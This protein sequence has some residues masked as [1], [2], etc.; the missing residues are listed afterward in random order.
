MIT[1]EESGLTGDQYAALQGIVHD[2]TY[3]IVASR[4]N[5]A[6][7]EIGA[8]TATASA[9]TDQTDACVV[10]GHGLRVRTNGNTLYVDRWPNIGQASATAGWD[11]EGAALVWSGVDSSVPPGL[12]SSG[13]TV[14]VFFYDGTS[15]KYVESTDA[16]ESWGSP[17]TAVAQANV[18][19]LAPTKLTKVHFAEYR[20]DF[21]TRLHYAED[22]SGWDTVGSE[23][24]WSYLMTGFDAAALDADTDVIV[25]SSPFPVN[26][27]T[28]AV[29]ATVQ[30]VVYQTGGVA[31][32]IQ[33]NE[34]W[35]D[36]C[37]IDVF[38]DESVYRYR[39]YPRIAYLND[40]LMVICAGKDGDEQASHF[41]HH[42]YT[43]KDG[44][45]WRFEDLVL[46]GDSTYSATPAIAGDFCFLVTS[47][48]VHRS[49][50]TG[51]IGY[52]PSAL[53]DDITEHLSSYSVTAGSMRQST[54][55]IEVT[56]EN[57]AWYES[58]ILSSEAILMLQHYW[59]TWV[60]GVACYVLVATEEVDVR[61]VVEQLPEKAVQIVS[62]DRMAWM[63]DRYSPAHVM[64]RTSQL[65]GWDDHADEADSGYGGLRHTAVQTGSWGTT[66]NTL[67]LT[68]SNKEG[69]AFSTFDLMVWNGSVQADMQWSSNGNGE[70]VGLVFRALDKDNMWNARYVQGEDKIVLFERRGG[71]DFRR[72][73]STAL[74]WSLGTWYSIK[75]VCRYA[76]VKVYYSTDSANWTKV[77]E[78]IVPGT[79]TL[80]NLDAVVYD[81]GAFGAIGY[82]YSD[83]DN[84]GLPAYEFPELTWDLDF[85]Y[86]P[87]DYGWALSGANEGEHLGVT[88]IGFLN[89]DGYFYRTSD[90]ESSS[91]TYTRVDLGLDGDPVQL[92]C[93][94]FS[95]GYI[96]GSGAVNAWVATTTGIY[97]VEDL[98]GTPSATLQHTFDEVSINRSMDFGF[99][100]RGHGACT[101]LYASGTWITYTLDGGDTWSTETMYGS[102]VIPDV[103][104]TGEIETYSYEGSGNYYVSGLANGNTYLRFTWEKPAGAWPFRYIRLPLEGFDTVTELVID[105]RRTEAQNTCSSWWETCIGDFI[106]HI[107]AFTLYYGAGHFSTGSDEI[108]DGWVRRTYTLSPAS[109]LN[110]IRTEVRGCPYNAGAPG[111]P[112]G[113]EFRIYSVNGELVDYSPAA[114]PPGIAVSTINDGEV[115][116]SGAIQAGADGYYSLDAGATM[117]RITSPPTPAYDL[118]P[119]YDLCGELN[120]PFAKPANDGTMLYGG[121]DGTQRV[122]LRTAADGITVEDISPLFGGIKYA[123]WQS[124]WQIIASYLDSNLL[125]VF[126]RDSTSTN[127][128]CWKSSD[129]G[130]TWICILTPGSAS[131][132]TR[133]AIAGNNSEIL[134]TWGQAGLVGYSE[135]GGLTIQDKTGNIQSSWPT[136]IEHIGAIGG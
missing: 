88:T 33:R 130:N 13:D 80:T 69:I 53:Q 70:Y 47:T 111:G 133:G 46:L 103:Y 5:L 86:N 120:I 85:N 14:R 99:G 19:Y 119:G 89:A 10:G 91:P 51:L 17:Q 132:M 79:R 49:Y 61:R 66:S 26:V 104:F 54:M 83:E 11:T 114:S 118:D 4:F 57:S 32:I 36:H 117:N 134:Y 58:S 115:I 31:A 75:V 82:G 100:T 84:W 35:S 92:V 67:K 3:K 126:G 74:S 27:G 21:T 110:D 20:S 123:P 106:T 12:I 40:R 29:G 59:G 15:I 8:G 93:D 44:E 124:R 62:R 68:A 107:P 9:D 97:F 63:A 78:Y 25:F 45:H 95:P 136:A 30:K 94:A 135:D 55:T 128:G 24:Y 90:F 18:I 129:G 96:A 121:N 108:V 81:R 50:Q 73:A 23:F 131:T 38:D 56:P 113:M 64:E 72:A 42:F 2:P 39:R 37:D 43:S 52:I 41:C 1:Q 28:R 22:D 76:L 6:F 125:I 98:F 116:T 102:A 105:M 71:S 16:G 65:L 122:L 7:S 112:C 48:E 109:P 127:I 60:D 77:I 101:S 87:L 34:H